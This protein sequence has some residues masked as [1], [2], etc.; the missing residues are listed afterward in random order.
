MR[1]T[2]RKV[3]FLRV[4]A[5][6]VLQSFPADHRSVGTFQFVSVASNKIIIIFVTLYKHIFL[7]TVTVDFPPA[8]ISI[9]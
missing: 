1:E 8:E 5:K 6:E 4:N 3:I 7:F 9:A 2:I